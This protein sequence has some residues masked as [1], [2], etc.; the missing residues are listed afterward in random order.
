MTG[1]PLAQ[2]V[3]TAVAITRAADQ[4]GQLHYMAG[5]PDGLC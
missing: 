5:A 3:A 1:G 4:L 2:T